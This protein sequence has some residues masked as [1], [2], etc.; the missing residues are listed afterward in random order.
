ME[1]LPG[2]RIFISESDANLE[3]QTCV[4]RLLAV[5]SGGVGSARYHRVVRRGSCFS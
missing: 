1:S 3:L 2:A 5:A 4:E